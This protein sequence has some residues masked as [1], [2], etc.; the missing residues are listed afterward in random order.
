PLVFD[1]MDRWNGRSLG[2]CTYY[3]S[4]PGG[5]SYDRVPVNASEAE[6]RRA[7]RFRPDGHTPGPV[8]LADHAPPPAVATAEYPYTVDLRRVR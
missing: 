7:S 3:V 5:L 4:H 2:G 6:T 1:L 8:D